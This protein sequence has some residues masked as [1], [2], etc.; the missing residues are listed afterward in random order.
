MIDKQAVEAAKAFLVNHDKDKLDNKE[1][2]E[3]YFDT[4][5][6][7]EL[8]IEYPSGAEDYPGFS[9]KE[10]NH[11]CSVGEVGDFGN[12]KIPPQDAAGFLVAC[13]DSSYNMLIATTNNKQPEAEAMLLASGFSPV[14]YSKANDASVLTLWALTVKPAPTPKAASKPEKAAKKAT[15]K[16]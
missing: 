3:A 10:L 14:N 15:R 1:D 6:S 11:A 8:R 16:K 7:G 5:D 2:L 12:G 13:D 9:L 4:G